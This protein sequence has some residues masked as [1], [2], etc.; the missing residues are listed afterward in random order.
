MFLLCW[1]TF[2]F[3][4]T[5]HPHNLHDYIAHQIHIDIYLWLVGDL[6][7]ALIAINFSLKEQRYSELPVLFINS[8][9]TWAFLKMSEIKQGSSWLKSCLEAL[10]T[11][12]SCVQLLKLAWFFWKVFWLILL[13]CNLIGNGFSIIVFDHGFPSTNSFQ[14]LPASL[15]KFIFFIDISH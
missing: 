13:V 2:D 7:S 9:T 10:I 1:F 3:S 12:W 11:E 15:H 6:C 8:C 14:I 5:S 4:F